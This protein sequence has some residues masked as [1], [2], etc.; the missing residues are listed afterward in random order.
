MESRTNIRY[1]ISLQ[2]VLPD[3]PFSECHTRIVDATAA[4]VWQALLTLSWTDLRVS[5]PLILARTGGRAKWERRPVLDHGP[6]DEI[7]SDPP[8]CWVGGRIGKPW[9][10]RPE[11]VEGPLS[12]DEFVAFDEPG[13]LKYGMDFHLDA[14]SDGRTVVTTAT[15]CTPTDDAAHRRFGHYW[16]VIR[17]F[18]GLVRRDMLRALAVAAEDAGGLSRCA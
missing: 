5:L 12:L 7:A 16:R 14:L 11:F 3:A 15:R 4:G 2:A 13:W 1:D 6:V 9:Q 8:R 17:P 10:P 18:S